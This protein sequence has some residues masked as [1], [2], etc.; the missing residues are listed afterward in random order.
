M[1]TVISDSLLPAL[2][3]IIPQSEHDFDGANEHLMVLEWIAHLKEAHARYK[4]VLIPEIELALSQYCRTYHDDLDAVILAATFNI[5][6][7]EM[8]RHIQHEE[9]VMFPLMEKLTPTNFAQYKEALE[10]MMHDH[11]SHEDLMNKILIHML[12]SP[13]PFLRSIAAKIKCLFDEVRSHAQAED[14]VITKLMVQCGSV[15]I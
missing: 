13:Q 10:W 3:G 7:D 5:Y 15:A 4:Q 8:L 1:N 11:A 6:K 9:A 14:D 2:K 12:H